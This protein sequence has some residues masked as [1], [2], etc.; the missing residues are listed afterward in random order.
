MDEAVGS[1]TS[2]GVLVHRGTA[3]RREYLFLRVY[4][5]LDLPK[6]VLEAGEEEREGALRE[7]REETAIGE[8]DVRMDPAFRY[9]TAYPTT[10]RGKRV[11]KTLIVFLAELLRPV[12]IRLTEHHAALWLGWPTTTSLPPRFTGLLEL[13]A[14]HL[15]DR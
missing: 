3:S 14:A 13:A 12:A 10:W 11:Q 5:T 2:C 1:V 4:R 9:V 7:L 8:S 6:G 15:G